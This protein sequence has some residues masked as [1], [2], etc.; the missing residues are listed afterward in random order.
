MENNVEV[1]NN[2]SELKPHNKFNICFVNK[3]N[4]LAAAPMGTVSVMMSYAL[5]NNGNDVTLYIGGEHDPDP[6]KTLRSKYGLE[7]IENLHLQV[8]PRSKYGTNS[9]F[10]MNLYF[11]AFQHIIANHKKGKQLIIISRNTNFLPLMWLLKK[12]TGAQTFFESHSFHNR[13]HGGRKWMGI[14]PRVNDIQPWFYEYFI[15]PRLTGILCITKRQMR[16][17][18]SVMP[19]VSSVF[20]P[21]GSPNTEKTDLATVR[22]RDPRKFVYCGRLTGHL[23]I[24]TFFEA[25]SVCKKN[26]VTLTWYGLSD[27]DKITLS[28]FA[29]KHNV[30]DSVFLE[31]RIPYQELRKKMVADFGIGLA[32]Y[33]NDYIS[34]VLT[35]PTK[36]V[37]YYTAGLPVI[38]TKISTVTD[39]LTNEQEGLV[40]RYGDT[41][42]LVK[43][44]ERMISDKDLYLKMHENCLKSAEYFSWQNRAARLVSFAAECAD[45]KTGK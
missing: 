4:W 33:N 13:A 17:Y 36:I 19:S 8:I 29:L 18:K 9:K 45:K 32:N 16:L 35:C 41:Q 24:A 23:D 34:A 43:C 31:G 7:P 21:L 2:Y 15:L 37:D 22:A 5:A 39:I 3:F 38:A 12:I 1:M 28:S 10:A 44:I 6:Q 26:G 42:S 40:Y 20:L 27:K 30:N 14:V 11:K 25:L